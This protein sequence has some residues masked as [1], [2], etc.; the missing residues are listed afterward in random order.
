MDTDREAAARI[1]VSVED[2]IIRKA[3][4][5]EQRPLPRENEV[6]R[7]VQV[8]L[9]KD[10][11]FNSGPV[12]RELA[13]VTGDSLVVSLFAETVKGIIQAET[14]LW[15]E[16]GYP[17]ADEYDRYWLESFQGNCRYYSN[18]DRV[19]Q[20][21]FQHL[22]VTSREGNLF[23][24]FKTQTLYALANGKFLLNGIF[25]DSFHEVS[26]NL[27]LGLDM[28][29]EAAEGNLLRAPDPVCKESNCFLADLVGVRLQGISKK[30]L[31]AL[32]GKEH[33][34]VHL[35]DVA[36]DAAQILNGR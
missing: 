3:E 27:T 24:R 16:R 32:L 12:L 30:D 9:G 36:F 11:Y 31:A 17:S 4:W 5:E 13:A 34:C 8:L 21:W 35:I 6:I 29:V 19:T 26:V 15:A 33:G 25:S 2:F 22:G 14:F 7:P 10:A 1:Q 23:V 18:L 20:S 28:I